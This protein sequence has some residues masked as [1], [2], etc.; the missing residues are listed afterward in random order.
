MGETAWEALT[1]R[2]EARKRRGAIVGPH[3]SGKT[4]L[5][6]DF[7]DRL[8]A[9]GETV[10]FA[11]LNDETHAAAFHKVL[12]EAKA[13]RPGTI[14]FLDGGEW[15]SRWNRRRLYNTTR[16]LRGIL[17]SA[18]RD[19]GL[20]VIYRTRP[21]FHVLLEI[22]QTLQERPLPG[23]ET[24]RLHERFAALQGNIRD[25]IRSCY[26]DWAHG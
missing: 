1:C 7:R 25:V 23:A 17:V 26:D 6:E 24:A 10:R 18:H 14:L 9:C 5:M 16:A 2:W 4:T 19:C 13:W 11:R 12:R 3:G 15:V 20:P 8:A 22:A 21:Q